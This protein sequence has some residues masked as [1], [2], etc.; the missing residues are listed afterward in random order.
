MGELFLSV[1]NMM[2]MTICGHK[3]KDLVIL[4]ELVNNKYI[5]LENEM[6]HIRN[7]Y[8]AGIKMAQKAMADGFERSI[9]R[10]RGVED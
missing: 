3:V 4:A 2:D 5:D 10:M 7:G 9:K 6:G 8:E 1:D